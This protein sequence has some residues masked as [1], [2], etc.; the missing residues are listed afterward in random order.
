MCCNM[1]KIKSTSTK[2]ISF[3]ACKDKI[4]QKKD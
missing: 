3:F 2:R 1:Y 4:Q